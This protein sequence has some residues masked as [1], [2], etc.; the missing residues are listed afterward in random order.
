MKKIYKYKFLIFYIL[1]MCCTFCHFKNLHTGHKLIELSDIESLQKENIAIESVTSDFNNIFQKAIDLKNKIEN[2]INSI[3]QLY[4]KKI[5]DL[6][7][8]YLKKHEQLIK[9]ENDLKEKL[10]NEVTKIKE[11]LENFLS[12]SNNEI[13][14][15]ENINKGIK[16]IEN[17][18]KNMIKILSYISKINKTKKNIKILLVEVMKNIKFKYE[19]EKRNIKYEENFFNGIPIPKNIEFK[20][21]TSSSLNISWTIDNIN[22]INID[23]NTIKYQV[24]IRKEKEIFKKVYEGNNNNFSINNL[25]TDTSYEFRICSLY[26]ELNGKWT[27]IQKI[28]TLQLD[29]II[30][31]E[32]KRENEFLN[33]IYEWTGFNN[34]EL[35]F[36]G[37]K[38]GMTNTAFHNKC[39]NKGQTI[40]LIKNDKGNIF[41]GYAS[42]SWTSAN[43][44]YI[45]A[46]E[47]FLF[48]L[49]NIHNTQP[50]KFPSKN[51]KKEIKQYY[52]Y[53]PSF[54]AGHD[55]GIYPDILNDGGWS[56][57]PNTYQDIL[58]KGKTIFTGN[59][60]NNNTNFKVK[61]I[62]VFKIFKSK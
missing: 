19:D 54:G 58:G 52:L 25:T 6:T 46:P 32:S 48:T 29:S 36:R 33:I 20:D 40:N 62:E 3:N 21:V 26:N 50:T 49:T 11:Q 51:D 38:D 34:M 37:T 22:N 60:N 10:Q 18:E 27:E 28:K 13:K 2:E 16:K 30:L 4:E 44:I 61:E 31:E 7:N 35:I 59:S 12:K 57:F 24:E 53:G 9:E 17:E 41:G 39:D 56:G 14:I 45:S 1:E 5:N 8:S 15:S 23:N 42:I 55:L 43:S 47:S